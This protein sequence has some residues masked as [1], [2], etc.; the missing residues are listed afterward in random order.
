VNAAARAATRPRIEGEREVAIFDAT[1]RMLA[2][3]GYDRL[4]MD[5]VAADAHASKATLY[6][7]WQTKADLVVDA[8]VWL[9]SCMP[10]DPP[11]TGS[12]RGDL[13]AMACN[14]GGLTD[15]MPLA[16]FG[17]LITAM[18]RDPV[19]AKAFQERFLAPLER[20]GRLIFE[21][22]QQRGEV[23]PAADLQLM[24][25]LLP[26]VTI[27][28]ALTRGAAVRPNFVAQVI[29]QVV[30]PACRRCPP[31]SPDATSAIHAGV[32]SRRKTRPEASTRETTSRTTPTKDRP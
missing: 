15:E 4:T 12:L 17:A 30:V 19:L 9:K 10:E 29:D 7:R 21:R 22:A 24:A 3:S 2:T 32:T 13:L 26:A 6:R 1:L 5:A 25:S 27:H 8:L 18:Q 14:P 20:R 23:D 31:E 16:V 28:R 11:D